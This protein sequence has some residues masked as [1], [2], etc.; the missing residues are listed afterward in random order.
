MNKR[1]EQLL[2]QLRDGSYKQYRSRDVEKPTVYPLDTFGFNFGSSYK[3]E[4]GS[5][6]ITPNFPRA[7]SKGFLAI[8]EEIVDSIKR[9]DDEDKKSFGRQMLEVLDEYIEDAKAHV[10][11][12]KVV[13]NTRLC[14][15]MKRVPLY[16]ATSFFEACLAIRAIIYFLRRS[17]ATHLGLGRFDQYLYP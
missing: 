2:A 13:G 14:E 1:T 11:D 16:P 7:M 15:A 10:A 9:T 4:W 12:A 5:G 17:G 3:A 6:N 8:R